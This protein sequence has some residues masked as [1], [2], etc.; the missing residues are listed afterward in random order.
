MFGKS[1]RAEQSKNY[2]VL[3]PEQEAL[4]PVEINEIGENYLYGRNGT[5][6]KSS[7]AANYFR[8]AADRGNAEAQNN[9][10]N[11]LLNGLGVEQ[12]MAEAVKYFKMAAAQGDTDAQ[13]AIDRLERKEEKEKKRNKRED[14]Q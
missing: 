10:G 6:R 2:F 11:L 8:I 5:V 9:I 12:D 7:I 1:N 13:K 3:P 4:S 14:K